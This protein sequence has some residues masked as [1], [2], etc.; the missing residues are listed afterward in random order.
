MSGELGG[1][2]L[3][4]LL[5]FGKTKVQHL[6]GSFCRFFAGKC[7]LITMPK[8][9]KGGKPRWGG[10]FPNPNKDYPSDFCKDFLIQVIVAF[11]ETETTMSLESK[12]IRYEEECVEK[13]NTDMRDRILEALNKPQWYEDIHKRDFGEWMDK[14]VHDGLWNSNVM[15]KKYGMVHRANDEA[16]DQVVLRADMFIMKCKPYAKN[17]NKEG[18]ISWWNSAAGVAQVQSTRRHLI[19]LP[20]TARVIPVDNK[21]MR[22][23]YATIRKVRIEGC[24]EIQAFWEFAAKT[25]LQEGRRPELAK[26]EHNTESMAV[27]IPHDGVI[28]FLAVHTTR[29]EGYTYWWNGGTLREMLRMDNDYPDN[30]YVR[31]AYDPNISDEEVNAAHRLKRWRAKRTELAWALL[32]I[33]N[34]V[35][36]AGHLHNDISPD[37]VMF[38]FPQNESLVYIGVCDWGMTSTIVAP[39]KSLY[40]FTSTTERDETVR[41]RWWVDPKITY[42]HKENADV[43]N[44]P[45]YSKQSEEFAIGQIAMKINASCMSEAYH[46][47]QGHGRNNHVRYQHH[48][49]GSV[50]QLYLNRLCTNDGEGSEHA[51]G[52]SSLA[53][54]ISRFTSSFNWPTPVEHFR[55]QY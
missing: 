27:R 22:G 38:H 8:A 11:Y 25:S 3:H 12:Y 40:T 29:N 45:N 17:R 30:I 6:G 5:S 41:R 9:K 42:V 34:A 36:G 13:F 19:A 48:E 46:K 39:K 23:G 55:R 32:H 35:H 44:V 4:W 10:A 31:I 43:D 33:M 28:R 7:L 15:I 24:A 18:S 14:R 16:F 20:E 51:T 2:P 50:F 26:L 49:L 52:H 21:I 53:E 1:S 47:L 37:N 54:V